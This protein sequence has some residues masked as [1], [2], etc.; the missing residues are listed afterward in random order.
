MQCDG[1]K[2]WRE[3][4]IS[5]GHA[6]PSTKEAKSLDS[7]TVVLIFHGVIQCPT[8][9]PRHFKYQDVTKQATGWQAGRQT[10]RGGGVKG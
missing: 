4:N 10:E 3:T 7:F 2:A 1:L 8:D 9:Y 5:L 6:S